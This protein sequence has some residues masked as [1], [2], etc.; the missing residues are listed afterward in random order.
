VVTVPNPRLEGVIE[1][2]G[3]GGGAVTHP[4]SLH[5]SQLGQL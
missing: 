2:D 1:Q 5:R 3:A 4:V